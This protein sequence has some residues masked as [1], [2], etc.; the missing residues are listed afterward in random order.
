MIVCVC[1]C[2]CAHT[3]ISSAASPSFPL[4]STIVRSLVWL[5]G[6]SVCL[7][8][9]FSFPLYFCSS[10]SSKHCGKSRSEKHQAERTKGKATSS[11]SQ[12][13]SPCVWVIMAKQQTHTLSHSLTS[14]TQTSLLALLLVL[15]G[16]NSPP[17]MSVCLSTELRAA[18]SHSSLSWTGMS[19]R[20]IARSLSDWL[21]QRIWLT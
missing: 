11:V 15:S 17:A 1:V 19:A 20:Q 21:A 12:S 9:S 8:H 14:P 3:N 6:R 10:S 7:S 18:K 4:F 16:S 2:V 5:V 13:A